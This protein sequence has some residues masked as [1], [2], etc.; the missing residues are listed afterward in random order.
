MR[1]LTDPVLRSHVGPLRNTA[2]LG[3]TRLDAVDAVLV[4]HV[5]HDHLD[6]PSLRR[7]PPTRVVVPTGA[8]GLIDGRHGVEEL[9][10]GQPT[11]VGPVTVTA[12][13]AVHVANRRPGGR[14]VEAVGHLVQGSRSAYVAGD[15]ALFPEM[16]EHAALALD[17]AVLPVGGWG[18]TLGP[19]HLDPESAALALT[20]LRPRAAVPVHWGSLRVPVAWRLRPDRYALPGQRFAAAARR[21]APEVRVHVLAASGRLTLRG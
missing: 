2:P 7:L 16:A 19:G 1:I 8:A 12:V 20:L 10:A 15:T 21:V 5:H 17:L 9:T 13:R 18:L 14:P 4:S 3:P 11:T 6:L